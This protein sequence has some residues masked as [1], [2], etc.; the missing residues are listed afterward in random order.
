MNKVPPSCLFWCFA[1]EN[2]KSACNS[3]GPARRSGRDNANTSWSEAA[4]AAALAIWYIARVNTVSRFLWD[5]RPLRPDFPC[6]TVRSP[7]PPLLHCFMRVI[8]LS[9]VGER[10]SGEKRKHKEELRSKLGSLP[11][12]K[13]EYQRVMPEMP[14]EEPLA[15]D[16]VD[17]EDAED[18]EARQRVRSLPPFNRKGKESAMKAPWYYGGD[19]TSL[20]PCAGGGASE[21]AGRIE[22]PQHTSPERSAEADRGSAR[23]DGRQARRRGTGCSS[24]ARRR[25]GDAA[26]GTRCGRASCG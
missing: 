24:A 19:F 7:A 14:S 23:D 26:C 6:T 2:A 17:D 18:L 1:D 16:L 25:G 11:E 8:E 12:P 20:V 9:L 10:R 13:M 4:A 3:R 15:K 5:Q 21:E 22:A